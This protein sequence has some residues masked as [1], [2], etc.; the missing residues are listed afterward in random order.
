MLRADFGKPPALDDI[1]GN[2][3]RF[4]SLID[5]ISN[6]QI[7]S[8]GYTVRCLPL[9]TS[10]SSR[11]TVGESGDLNSSLIHEFYDFLICEWILPLS[12]TQPKQLRILKEKLIRQIIME[13]VLSRTVFVRKGTV[14]EN[15]QKENEMFIGHESQSKWT[16]THRLDLPLQSM[17]PEFSQLPSDQLPSSQFPSSQIESS[18][19]SVSTVVPEQTYPTLCRYTTMKQPPLPGRKVTNTLSHWQLGTDPTLYDWKATTQTL[20]D[21]ENMSEAQ[22]SR[23]WRR[24][25]GR[26][27]QRLREEMER[28]RQMSEASSRVPEIRMS[29]SQPT[30]QR[31]TPAL[32][33]SQIT[34]IPMSQIESG[35]VGSRKLGGGREGRKKRTAGF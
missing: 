30:S 15:S 11:M 17:E 13:L 12:A 7:L 35:A 34:D 23:Q 25:R 31:A 29:G 16:S 18:Q 3:S 2:S 21:E 4:E 22:K 10:V 8:S 9:L 33:S 24:K 32:L 1:E 28:E 20:Q 19:S 27:K 5:S 14:M 6:Y 26:R